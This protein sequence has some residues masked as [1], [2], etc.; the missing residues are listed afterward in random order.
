MFLPLPPRRGNKG[1]EVPLNRDVVFEE[2]R[3]W[4][5]GCPDPGDLAA[6]ARGALS[7]DKVEA[8]AVHIPNCPK[9]SESLDTVVEDDSLII[10]LRQLLHDAP[11]V[12]PRPAGSP[13]AKDRP[14][15]PPERLGKYLIKEQLGQGSM[16]IVYRAIQDG[17][18]RVVAIKLSSYGSV[19]NAAAA[20]RL[21]TE[22]EAIGRLRHPHI[23]QVHEFDEHDGVPYFSME[24]CGGGSL[25]AKLILGHLPEREAAELVRDLAL[26]VEYAHDHNILHRDLKPG[27][28]L[29]DDRGAV[30]LTDFGLAK[31]I[32]TAGNETAS[33]FIMGTPSY[34]APEQAAGQTRKVGPHTDVYG[35]GAILYACLTGKPPFTGATSIEILKQVQNSWPAR[36]AQLRSG[37]SPTLES[38]CLKCLERAPRSRYR[39]AKQLAD[40]LDRWL[41]GQKPH[42]SKWRR[43]KRIWKGIR[44]RTIAAG[45][46][47]VLGAG[48]LAA[49]ALYLNPDRAKARALARLKEELRT[50]NHVTLIGQTGQP[51]W[52]RFATDKDRRSEFLD[53]EGTFSVSTWDT[54]LV[55]LFPD[56]DLD[57]YV[58]SAQVRHDTAALTGGV[59]LYVAGK[60]LPPDNAS[61]L[62]FLDLSFNVVRGVPPSVLRTVKTAKPALHAEQAM[63]FLPLL[64]DDLRCIRLQS[65]SG[66]P[67]KTLGN[68]NGVWHNLSLTMTPSKV[69]ATF[70][71]LSWDIDT[72]SLTEEL[73][74]KRRKFP[75]D[76]AYQALPPTFAS[77]GSIGLYLEGG[78][79]GFRNVTLSCNSAI[80][81]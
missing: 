35:L 31:L 22:C 74:H 58:Y 10:D 70:N 65:S 44:N 47:L 24:Y 61:I 60:R 56:I 63:H 42:A 4:Y 67:L 32:D 45:I 2:L 29:F 69:T 46:F 40:D 51:R 7:S 80:S 38:I 21:R 57:S 79:A 16:G 59:G 50:T 14:C 73:S 6:F 9:C 8:I 28:V 76:H 19:W 23:V 78:S 34:M 68:D 71:G 1:Y 62:F 53:P 26:A 20:K 72:P 43:V 39:S 11:P 12:P 49:F 5:K 25:A 17:V 75:N 66:P 3:T 33:N 48:M 52:H 55:E 54:T 18:N 36:P 15:P 41:A 77:T 13:A 37:L 64:E 30:R 81:H 27:N